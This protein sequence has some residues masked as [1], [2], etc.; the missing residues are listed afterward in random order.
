MKTFSDY[1]DNINEK[2]ENDKLFA[3]YDRDDIFINYYYSND[4]AKAAADE[5]NNDTPSMKYHVVTI[6]KSDVE[7]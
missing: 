2:A 1:I 3:V 6:N 5:L 7:K 4:D